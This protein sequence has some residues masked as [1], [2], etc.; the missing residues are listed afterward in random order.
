MTAIGL[1]DLAR[2]Y[3]AIDISGTSQELH[4]LACNLYFGIVLAS[5]PRKTNGALAVAPKRKDGTPL[6][7]RVDALPPEQSGPYFLPP[8]GTVDRDEAVPDAGAAGSLEIKEWQAIINYLKS[9]PTKNA[10]G[11]TVLALDEHTNE[12]RSSDRARGI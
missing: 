12:N 1:G 6:A 9:L 8:R 3:R 7:S 5:I 2:G 4:S 11:L 10:Q